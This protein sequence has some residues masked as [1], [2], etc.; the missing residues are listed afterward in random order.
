[1]QR[2]L[3][4][5][6]RATSWVHAFAVAG[7]FALVIAVMYLGQVILMPLALAI[8]MSFLLQPGV[9]LLERVGLWRVPAV[10]VVVLLVGMV[11]AVLVWQVSLQLK[12]LA[13]DLRTNSRYIENIEKKMEDLRGLGTEG[14]WTDFQKVIDRFSTKIET[15]EPSSPPQG[16]PVVV[17]DVQPSAWEAVFASLEPLFAP[18]GSAVLVAVLLVFMLIDRENL[19]NRIIELFGRGRLA[20]TT[21]AIDDAGHRIGRYLLM[22]FVI[23]ASYGL[24][25]T[26]VLGFIGVPFSVL[27]GFLAA[28]LR[29]VPYIGP[30]MAAIFPLAI[31]LVAF[32]GWQQPLLVLCFIVTLELFSNMVMEPVLYGHSVGIS[33]VALIISASFWTL[34]WGPIGL[35]LATPL[36]VCLVVLGQ[37]VPQLRPFAVLLSDTPALPP[38]VHYY[39][40]LLAHDRDEAYKLIRQELTE[41]KQLCRVFDSIVMSALLRVRRDRSRDELSSDDA[42]YVCKVT[43][44]LITELAAERQI[45]MLLPASSKAGRRWWQAEGAAVSNGPNAVLSSAT[46]LQVAASLAVNAAQDPPQPERPRTRVLACPA[47]HE[48]E[49][50]VNQML[51]CALRE[52][53]IEVEAV[54][55]RVLFSNLLEQIRTHEI[56]IVFIAVLPPGGLTQAAYLCRQ[57]RKAYPQLTIIIGCWGRKSRFDEILVKLR[58]RGANYVATS[59]CQVEAQV[60]ALSSESQRA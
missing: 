50:L 15:A 22:Q 16:T 40:R 28:I 12:D 5:Q 39:Q 56:D 46:S 20:L 21:R 9:R 42:A 17:Q 41:L 48:V 35:V 37:H 47:H 51:G 49:E 59:L 24:L 4:S 18:L 33:P 10:M 7:C 55:T 11:F 3:R 54:S 13:Y 53:S 29:Y 45:A 14:M 6:V 32:E 8:V 19:R 34:L 44:E 52:H 38:P 31:G 25:M 1:M 23:N 26:V 2:L 43:G 30:W 27:W 36:T 60:L 57:F 58:A